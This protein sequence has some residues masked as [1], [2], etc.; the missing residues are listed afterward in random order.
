MAM[1]IKQ[2]KLLLENWR[3][4]LNESQEE[5]GLLYHATLAGKNNE[6]LNSFIQKGIDPARAGGFGQGKGF[7]LWNTMK[8]AQWYIKGLIHGMTGGEKEEAV[9]GRPVVIVVDEPITPQNFDIDYELYAKGFI[10]FV[11]SNLDY[12]KKHADELG[13]IGRML[14][15]GLTVNR[16]V[17]G[18]SGPSRFTIAS[19]KHREG[20]ESDIHSEEYN[21]SV[22][23]GEDLSAVATRLHDLDP[24]KFEEFETKML[25]SAR[26]IKYNGTEK[27]WPLRIEDTEGNVLWSRQ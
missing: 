19:W 5:S 11:E 21:I 13:I 12:F 15:R 24:A 25:P 6:I 7:Y 18:T 23:G 9:T 2:M 1:E 20:W 8:D 27:I 22:G 4:Y 26:A 3:K 17:L 14:D 10:G 16:K